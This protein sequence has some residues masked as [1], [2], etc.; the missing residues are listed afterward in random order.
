MNTTF[1]LPLAPRLGEPPDEDQPSD[2][3]SYL[4]VSRLKSFLSCRLKFYYEKV[5]G[6]RPPTSPNFQI[7]KA[8]HA[9]LQHYHTARW[10]GGDA[11]PEPVVQAYH[12]A[13]ADLEKDD[14]VDYGDK[15]RQECV[16]TGERVLRA[17]LASERATDPRRILGV[18]VYLRM[19]TGNLPIPLVGVLDLV[20]EGNVPVDFKTVHST[21]DLEDEAWQNEIQLTAY[22]MLLEDATGEVPG[23]GELIYLAKLKT[24]KI[25]KQTLTPV[26]AQRIDRFRALA[27]R[28][29]EGVQREEY[30]PSPGMACRW[31][32]FR[33]QGAAWKGAN[34]A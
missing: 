27:D 18:E 7:G 29:V 31:C 26:D 14:P 23:P 20:V 6:L 11:S 19:E 13:F 10:R 5:R 30:Y 33:T 4:S 1:E 8:V 24:P 25:L 12:A 22:H 28:Y 2:P 34:V 15:D 21:P 3:L 9:G 32:S 16:D 17:Y